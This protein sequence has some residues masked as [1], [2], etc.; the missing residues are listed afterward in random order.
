MGVCSFLMVWWHRHSQRLLPYHTIRVFSPRKSSGVGCVSPSRA[1]PRSGRA[2]LP[3]PPAGPPTG[4]PC[5][6]GRRPRVRTSLRFLLLLAGAALDPAYQVEREQD[7]DHRGDQGAG[8]HGLK[9]PVGQVAT[10]LKGQQ[11]EQGPGEGS[12][13]GQGQGPAHPA[14]HG[15][16]GGAVGFVLVGAELLEGIDHAVVFLSVSVM[17]VPMR[18]S[19]SALGSAYWSAS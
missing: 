1:G 2:R 6:P 17:I 3:G 19:S 8:Q 4:R 14:A 11:S 16:G 13:G 5:R 10:D 9:L 12:C 7:H 15:A 18:T